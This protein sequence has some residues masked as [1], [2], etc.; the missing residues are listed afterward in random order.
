MCQF[1]YDLEIQLFNV[2]GR[3]V[4]TSSIEVSNGRLYL[5]NLSD[6]NKGTYLMIVSSI[7]TGD[8]YKVKF[9]KN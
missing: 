4:K 1:T 9:I 5:N 2:V 7:Q 3:L 8:E 6:L